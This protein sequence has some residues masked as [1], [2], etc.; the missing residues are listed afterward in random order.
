MRHPRRRYPVASALLHDEPAALCEP[1][2]QARGEFVDR[3]IDGA[4]RAPTEVAGA[5]EDLLRPHFLDHLGVRGD[6]DA[7]RRRLLQQL[8]DAAARDAVL[9]RV[10]PHEHAVEAQQLRADSARPV[11]AKGQGD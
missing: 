5:V 1:G 8:V 4:V 3:T 9:D 2:R 7:L 10:D 11:I 6:P